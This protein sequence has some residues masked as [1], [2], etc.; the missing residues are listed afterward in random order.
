M[1]R[2]ALL[3][4]ISLLVVVV[5]IIILFSTG[6][7]ADMPT[8]IA[9]IFI[10]IFASSFSNYVQTQTLEKYQSDIISKMTISDIKE[11]LEDK[12]ADTTESAQ[13]LKELSNT[14]SN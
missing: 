6:Y 7:K 12:N 14:R 4:A 1:N 3:P 11:V 5:I 2:L 10:G 8:L 9:S 13:E